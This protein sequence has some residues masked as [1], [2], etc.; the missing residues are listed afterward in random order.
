MHSSYKSEHII[1]TK[2]YLILCVSA[3][4]FGI[5]SAV[6]Y[7]KSIALIISFV[8][9]LLLSALSVTIYFF[10]NRRE[11]R[12]KI[13]KFILLPLFL[14]VFFT[15]GILRISYAEHSSSQKLRKYTDDS[16]WLYGTVSTAPNLTE[17][18]YYY[19]FEMQVRGISKHNES[20]TL[21][22]KIIIFTPKH[23]GENLNISDKISCWTDISLPQP[24]TE[25]GL[26]DYPTYLKGK[27]IFLVGN[28]G[29]VNPCANLDE[30]F[31]PS[32]FD[33]IINQTNSCG[34]FIRNGILRAVDA[35]FSYNSE[36]N[37]IIK[38]ILLGDKSSF[39]QD[40]YLRFSNA[41][42]SHI[43]AVSGMHLSIFFAFLCF[44]FSSFRI[45]RKIALLLC[46]PC[47]TLFISTAG[48]SPSLCRASLM[49]LLMI[50]ATLLSEEYNPL[51]ALFFA[52]GVLLCFIP[53]SLFSMGLL[54]SFGATFGILVYYNY[55]KSIA[56]NIVSS[57]LIHTML[58]SPLIISISAFIGTSY[59]LIL[60]V[61]RLSWIQIFTNLWVIPLVSIIFCGGYIIC[62][63]YYILPT[64]I[65]SF[66]K[67]PVSGAL[68]LIAATSRIFGT[69][70]F[71]FKIPSSFIT[72]FSTISYVI[73]A[74]LL[75]LLCK[76]ASDL[77]HGK[78][79][80]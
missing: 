64:A 6:M 49:L 42:I 28:T 32:F 46:V 21:K 39:S 78:S 10:K 75:Y 43:I 29:N 48:F 8:L 23:R 41:G 59:F 47:L 26:F 3:F 50:L 14:A 56:E 51:T 74:A 53:Y 11:G 9:F 35:L 63:L 2:H 58:L 15:A 33:N 61:E 76:N 7:G 19:S 52:L 5:C 24:E 4:T 72:T 17:S 18:G 27:N 30:L 40:L 44:A 68:E 1:T 13:K 34:I 36:A 12:L 25:T 71:A 73:I 16:I 22:D 77:L 45:H 62:G 31:P 65:V 38:G 80:R 67:L 79:M 60:F 66:L 69:D 70:F 55:L 54:L 20:Q 57:R 37:A